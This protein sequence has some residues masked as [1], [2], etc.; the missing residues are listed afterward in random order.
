MKKKSFRSFEDVSDS[1]GDE[2]KTNYNDKANFDLSA[3]RE[4]VISD[5]IGLST[6]SVRIVD[7]CEG[8][9]LW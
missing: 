2:M 5:A 9:G 1:T 3:K 7:I 8:P 4:A 6:K